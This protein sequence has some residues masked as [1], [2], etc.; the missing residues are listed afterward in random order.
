[1]PELPEVETIKS[2]LSKN[3][4]GKKITGVDFLWT[5]ILKNISVKDFIKQAVGQRILGVRRRAKNIDIMLSNNMYLLFHMKMTGHLIYTDD[6]WRVDSDGRWIHQGDKE[7]PLYDPLNQY[8]RVI[9]YLDAGKILAFSDLRKFAYLKLLSEDELEKSYRQ[10]GPEP[11]SAKFSVGYL[12]D[13]LSKK[14]VAI[15]KV[16]M[17]QKQI[18]GIG[19]IYA[20]E[21]LWEVK[22]HPLTLA[23]KISDDKIE[24]LHHVIQKILKEAILKRGTSISDFR[25]LDGKKGEYGKLLKA[26]RQT[27]LP[28]SRDRTPIERISVGGRGTHFCPTCQKITKDK[29]KVN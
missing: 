11:F 18:A 24:K 3:L 1:M 7:S 19:N 4:V 9:F 22:I 10:Y 20:D 23:N 27:G 6:C 5:G 26:Y 17:D 12:K 25:D 8:I 16:L 28:C 15:K 21:I 14:K 13:I 29:V 2:D